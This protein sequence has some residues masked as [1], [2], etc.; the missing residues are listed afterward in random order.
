L[1]VAR[2]RL[3]SGFGK[4]PLFSHKAQGAG[5]FE[6]QIIHLCSVANYPRAVPHP[7]VANPGNLRV[8][9]APK[10]KEHVLRSR[11]QFHITYTAFVRAIYGGTEVAL[12][13]AHRVPG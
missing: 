8:V 12:N 1:L 7:L 4:P 3:A 5:S 13:Q 10:M 9:R 11:N 6:T 2:R